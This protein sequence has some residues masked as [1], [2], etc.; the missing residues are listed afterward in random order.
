[1]ITGV[2]IRYNNK[3]YRLPKPNRHHNIIRTIAEENGEGIKG[4]DIQGFYTDTGIFLDRKQAFHW[5][6]YCNQVKPRGPNEYNG[7]QLFSEDLW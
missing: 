1:M 7:N 3:E 4:P 5:A 2:A 6:N